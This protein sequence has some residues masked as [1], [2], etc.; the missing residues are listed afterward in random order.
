MEWFEEDY[1]DVSLKIRIKE[2][3]ADFR[4]RYQR[5]QLFE[6]FSFGKMLVLD[7]KIQL[8]ERDEA[9]YHEML[10]H[11]PMLTH[12]N[13]EKVLIIGGGD[14]GSLREVLKHNPNEAILVELDR[15]V[16]DVCRKH[17]GIDEGAFETA[18]VTVLVEDGMDYVISAKEKFDV[19]I[20]DG[21]DP[22]PFSQ[23]I[24]SAEFYE[25]CKRISDVFATQSQSPFA[26]PDYFRTVLENIARVMDFRV[27]VNY[28]PSY[29]LGLW[30]YAIH[31]EDCP[32]IEELKRRFYERNIETVHYNPEIHHA[33]FY[34]PEWIKKIVNEV[35]NRNR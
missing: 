15:D 7:G 1:G 2:V 3:I 19:V 29:P 6:T 27:Y 8:T 21:T 10:V 18:N 35:K 26:Q 33:S 11:V 5:I 12:K 28:V 24:S 22:N 25:A 17:L 31:A 9:F 34:L 16:I 23:H 20:V 32:D 30:S 4:S 13:P 14:G